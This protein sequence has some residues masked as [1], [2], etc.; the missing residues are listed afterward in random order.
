[1]STFNHYQVECYNRQGVL[2]IERR[3]SYLKFNKQVTVKCVDNFL[4][5][6]QCLF[7]F[8]VHIDIKRTFLIIVRFF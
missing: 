7:S 6:S 4:L 2:G 3:N 8:L 5:K 1:M